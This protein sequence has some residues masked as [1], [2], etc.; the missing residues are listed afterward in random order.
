MTDRPPQYTKDGPADARVANDP[1]HLGPSS[2]MT[3]AD[4]ARSTSRGSTASTVSAFDIPGMDEDTAQEMSDERRDLPEG[5]VRCWDDKQQHHF[6]V[7]TATKRSIWIHP[8]DDPEYLQSLPDTHPANPNSKEAK[9]IREHAQAEEAMRKQ[10]GGG[11]PGQNAGGAGGEKRNWFQRKKDDIIGTKEERAHAKAEKKKRKEEEYRQALKAHEEYLD[12]RRKLMQHQLNNPSISRYYASNP[13][14]YPAPMTPYSRMGY[15]GMG[16]M[17]MG[18]MG[19]S[20]YGYGYGGGYGR[21]PMGGMGMGMP[22]FG[23]LAGG[24]LLG[25]AMGEYC[26][27]SKLFDSLHHE[28]CA[29]RQVVALVE[30]MAAAMVIAVAV[31]WAVVAMEAVAVNRYDTI[32]PHSYIEPDT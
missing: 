32:A 23:G 27:L 11:Q 17:G 30:D 13:Y 31:I 24:M 18:G 21:R 20:P 4:M 6:Y 22:L 25:S 12:R 10:R 2:A 15:G 29:D 16:G 5:W 9:A 19:M 26:Y 28:R 1:N 7:D 8:Y 3:G 14:G